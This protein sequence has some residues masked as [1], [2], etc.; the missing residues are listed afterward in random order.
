[1][2]MHLLSQQALNVLSQFFNTIMEID[3]IL[4][5][6]IHKFA[7]WHSGKSCRGPCGKFLRSKFLK[8]YLEFFLLD[9]PIQ[10][11]PQD[12]RFRFFLQFRQVLNLFEIWFV[13]PY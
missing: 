1:M 5:E 3:S 13:Y 9:A 6:N 10:N 7:K 12:A 8:C 4:D 2:E 11:F